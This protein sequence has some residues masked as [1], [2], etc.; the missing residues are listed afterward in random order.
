MSLVPVMSF[1]MLVGFA[2]AEESPEG[3]T[4]ATMGKVAQQV[5]I[6]RLWK[7]HTPSKA[8]GLAVVVPEPTTDGWGRPLIYTSPGPDG[9]AFGISSAGADGLAGGDDDLVWTPDPQRVE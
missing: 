4:R 6:F 3:T 8:E 5:E 7:G 2:E 9:Y 1:L